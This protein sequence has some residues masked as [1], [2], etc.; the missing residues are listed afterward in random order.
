MFLCC[1]W[2]GIWEIVDN[3][4]FFSDLLKL[5]QAECLVCLVCLLFTADLTEERGETLFTV[6]SLSTCF[7]C[8][9]FTD[10]QPAALSP[11]TCSVLLLV[12]KMDSQPACIQKAHDPYPWSICQF[13]G[14]QMFFT[15]WWGYNLQQP[16]VTVM[17]HT[18]LK[19]H[20]RIMT[21]DLLPRLWFGLSL[22]AVLFLIWT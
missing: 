10:F 8:R 14:L 19:S 5:E 16:P 20:T 18:D 17:S 15:E 11:G 13:C 2:G 4:R 3:F 12:R 6:L 9:L 21:E 7:S 22:W 1:F